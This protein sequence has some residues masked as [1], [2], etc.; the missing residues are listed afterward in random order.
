LRVR[1]WKPELQKL[2]NKSELD[3]VVSHVPS[4]ISKR[5]EI[6]RRLFSFISPNWRATPL[7]GDQVIVRLIAA[8]TTK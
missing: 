5:N 2:A 7:G 4:V 1:L 3:I 6:K 8:T